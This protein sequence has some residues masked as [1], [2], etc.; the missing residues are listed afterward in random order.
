MS[1][2]SDDSDDSVYSRAASEVTGLDRVLSDPR[3]L[4]EVQVIKISYSQI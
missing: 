2:H 1:E 4:K 3:S